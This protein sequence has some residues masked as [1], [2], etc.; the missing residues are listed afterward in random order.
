MGIEAKNPFNS[1]AYLDKELK[2][3]HGQKRQEEEQKKQHEAEVEENFK[4]IPER[5]RQQ[6]LRLAKERK[7]REKREKKLIE[8][9]NR[10][11]GEYDPWHKI[12]MTM[13]SGKGLEYSSNY[14]RF[15]IK[16]E[17][18]QK[19]ERRGPRPGWGPWHNR[20]KAQ[21]SEVLRGH[22]KTMK[23]RGID[24]TK[25]N[26]HKGVMPGQ[27]SMDIALERIGQET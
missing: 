1:R 9:S 12:H 2:N 17:V 10:I 5:A 23:E 27:L 19:Q 8:D 15:D 24:A 21:Q 11:D 18:K 13:W 26:P 22:I 25:I 16:W 7:E 20:T 4:T 14:L 6:G 3:F